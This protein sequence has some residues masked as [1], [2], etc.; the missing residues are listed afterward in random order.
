MK[1]RLFTSR[2]IQNALREARQARDESDYRFFKMGASIFT[3]KKVLTTGYNINKTCPLQKKYNIFRKFD[4]AQMKC[5]CHAEMSALIKLRRMYPNV[6]GNQLSIMIYRETAN[7]DLAMARP[8]PA[9]E[10]ALRD[11][12]ITD[13]Y[14]TGNNSLIYEKYLI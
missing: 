14:Y 5:C 7:G 6:K 8:C 2:I 10:K 12:G 4:T 1:Q 13:I 9:C 3:N 11:Y